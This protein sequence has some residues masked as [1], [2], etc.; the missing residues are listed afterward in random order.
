MPRTQ[1]PQGQEPLRLLLTQ[2]GLWGACL[3]SFLKLPGEALRA[4]PLSSIDLD[5]RS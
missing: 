1:E 5:E 2:H 3:G 4:A